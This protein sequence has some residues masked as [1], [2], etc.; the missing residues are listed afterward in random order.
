MDAQDHVA[1]KVLVVIPAYLAAPG[2]PGKPLADIGGEPMVVHVWRAAIEARVGRVVIATPDADIARAVKGFGG[3]ALTLSPGIHSG[4]VLAAAALHKIDPQGDVASI[5]TVRCDTPAIRPRAI[6]RCLEPLAD[7]VVDIATLAAPITREEDKS[8]PSVV[9][10]RLQLTPGRTIARV[11]D[12]TRITPRDAQGTQFQHIEVYAFRRSVLENFVL[13]PPSVR[14]TQQRLEQLRALD[15]GMRIDAALVDTAPPRVDT[16][17]DLE[18][19]R[20]ALAHQK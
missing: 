9:K 1:D 10:A 4:T 11:T 5:L 8:D 20:T 13:L 19:A 15:V 14:E 6:Q 12:F 2:L 7:P 17:A 16:P 3:N 18:I